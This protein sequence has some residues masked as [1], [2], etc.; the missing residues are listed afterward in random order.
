MIGGA[1]LIAFS[2]SVIWPLPK[3][4]F[5]TPYATVLLD[6][7]GTLIDAQI[8]KDGQ[9]RF[10]ETDHLPA[11][12]ATALITYEDEGFYHHPG[13]NPL[14]L[15][16]ALWQDVK[17]GHIVSGGSTLTM[18]L[19]RLHWAGAARTV[20]QKLKEIFM[21]FRLEWHFSKDEILRLY[22]SHAPFG[23]NIRGIDAASYRYFHRAP[24]SLSWA[25]AA[26]LAVLPNNP[27]MIYPGKNSPELKRKRDFLLQ[28][29]F[30][31]GDLDQR[32]LQLALAE[33]LPQK[34][35]AFPA[36]APHLLNHMLQ[37][38]QAGKVWHTT[39]D[40]PQQQALTQLTTRYVKEHLA[41]NQVFNAALVIANWQTGEVL[42]YVGNVPTGTDHEEAVDV[43]QAIRSP[44]SLLKP[45]LYARALEQ[46]LISPQQWLP[47]IPLFYKGFAPQ[48]FDKQF[49]GLVPANR[50]LAR[51]LNVPFVRLLR[52]Y[53]YEPFHQD[54]RNMGAKSLNQPADHYGLSL[55]L[56]GG[57]VT[58]WELCKLYLQLPRSA[59]PQPNGH[60][61]LHY[62]MKKAPRQQ[63]Y[64]QA[65]AA[66]QTLQ[67]MHELIR[68]EQE[69]G[70][71][72]FQSGREISWKTGTSFG[73][74]DAWAMGVS[75]QYVVGVW[76]GNADGEGRPGLVGVLAAAPLLFQVMDYLQ[77]E[78]THLPTPAPQMQH[79]A[80]CKETGFRAGPNCPNPRERLVPKSKALPPVCPF[81]QLLHLDHSGKYRVSSDCYPT[82]KMQTKKALI[83]PPVEQWYYQ[84]FQGTYEDLPPWKPGC[85]P[86]DVS[87]VM[88]MIYPEPNAKVFIPTELDGR[89][90]R[91]IVQVAHRHPETRI[92]WYLD[93]RYL[94]ETQGVHQMAIPGI[95]GEHELRLIDEKGNKL[96][97]AIRIKTRKN[98][99]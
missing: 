52:D 71:Q 13:V 55:I 11:K 62:V 54:L 23:G 57:D 56:G 58:L 42:T 26:T 50:A 83:L 14:A 84:R 39:L 16:R 70:W 67:V 75:Q 85:A 6:R 31:N 41:Y 17:A 47:D 2:L 46:G 53:G 8:A 88:E 97:T 98:A 3:P 10:P 24:E 18:Q 74:R 92:Y 66:W 1:I 4:F 49:H 72:W 9:W 61:D 22:A 91:L 29:L 51:S 93:S 40:E 77:A 27:S 63:G 87:E 33:P 28:K 76:T 25:E 89:P 19:A 90:G 5:N 44:G 43:V 30:A 95:E 94:G 69:A 78:G 60:A 7:Q 65:G 37:S 73:F 35:Y 48:N 38:G 34:Q 81:H 86:S 64:L 20:G 12:F 32:T 99:K 68:P 59:E 36:M 45:F 21:A 79:V 15:V 80:I 96:S 82:Y